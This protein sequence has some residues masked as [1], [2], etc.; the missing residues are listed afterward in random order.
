MKYQYNLSREQRFK[1]EKKVFS[2]YWLEHEWSGCTAAAGAL[3][4]TETAYC[5]IENVSE[6]T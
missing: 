1:N 5:G 3:G 2:V 6:A 4:E